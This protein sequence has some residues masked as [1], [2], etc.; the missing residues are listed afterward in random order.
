MATWASG[1]NFNY[2][3]YNYQDP[4]GQNV[5]TNIW[6]NQPWYQ[7][8]IIDNPGLGIDSNVTNPNFDPITGLPVIPGAT[9]DP[10]V[11]TGTGTGTAPGTDNGLTGGV[12]TYFGALE[13]TAGQN[14][15][16]TQPGQ[17]WLNTEEGQLWLTTPTG[18][19]QTWLNPT[20]TIGTGVDTGTGTGTGTGVTNTTDQGFFNI[21]SD[22][23]PFTRSSSS[24][25][26]QST[27]YGGLP[28]DQRNQ[29][30]SAILPQLISQINNMPGNIDDYTQNA[31]NQYRQLALK[32]LPGELTSTLNNLVSRNMLNSSVAGEAISD[33][34]GEVMSRYT[35]M[36]YNAAMTGAGMKAAMPGILGQL[37]NLGRYDTTQSTGSGTQQSYQ[38]NRLAPYQLL[39]NLLTNI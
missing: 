23:F 1:L 7:S 2:P 24:D 32:D 15:L 18:Q 28:E 22:I 9:T 36:A 25:T 35:P 10:G 5:G 8:A 27:S 39:V 29:L 31:L 4:T 3:G 6:A 38:E 33:V 19:S 37:A 14:W 20:G 21:P 30:L 34:T 26:R 17:D 11:G 12:E 16:R 13:S